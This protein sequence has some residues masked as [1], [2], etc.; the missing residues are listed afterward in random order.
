MLKF[1]KLNNIFGWVIF[2]IASFTYTLTLEPTVS[3]WDCGE[4]IA[5][6][7]KLEVGHPPGAPVYQLLAHVFSWFSA[8]DV[9]KVA[10]AMNML[11]ALAS[12][13]AVMF[14]FWTITLLLKKFLNPENNA[15]AILVTSTKS[16]NA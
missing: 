5:S 4:W 11:S 7:Y 16:L 2:F 1:R 14:L 8:G 3:F 15:F 13:F 12:A 10:L 6:S 9:S